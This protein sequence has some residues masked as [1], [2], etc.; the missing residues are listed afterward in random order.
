MPEFFKKFL[1]TSVG[2]A[3]TAS[4]RFQSM[5][6]GLVETGKVSQE[7]GK[8]IVDE[9]FAETEGRRKDFE[10]RL[11]TVV[12]DA[13]HALRLPTKA[14]FEALIERVEELEAAHKSA[15][16]ANTAKKVVATAEE[17][18]VEA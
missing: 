16:R 6:D 4:D 7:D 2:L 5:V 1:Y 11:Q 9:F 12:E 14:E 17:T 18:T 8:K 13:M 15:K 10:A 3:T